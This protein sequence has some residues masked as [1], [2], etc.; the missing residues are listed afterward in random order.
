M[1]RDLGIAEATVKVRV[2]HILWKLNLS[3]RMK[4]AVYLVGRGA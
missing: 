2:Q 3:L 1:P 4:A